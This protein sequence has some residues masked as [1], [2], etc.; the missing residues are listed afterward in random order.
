MMY[1]SPIEVVYGQLQTKFEGDVIKAVQSYHINVD[2]EELI[3]ALDY[4][5]DQYEAGYNAG[6]R[7]A[8][9][10][11]VL[12]KDCRHGREMNARE[13]QLYVAGCVMCSKIDVNGDENAML[14][15]D[16][17]SYGERKG[18]GE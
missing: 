13:S 5:R 12:C 1:K 10:D 6:F 18:E 4:D 7:A 11:I 8:R 9:S 2:K 17:C 15:S 3:K 14:A 16:F